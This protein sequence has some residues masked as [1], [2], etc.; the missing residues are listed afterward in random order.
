MFSEMIRTTLERE[1][2]GQPAAIAS[3]V[4]GITRLASGLTPRERSWCTYLFIGPPRDRTHAPG[5]HRGPTAAR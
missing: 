5:A 2:I 3:V 4:R 1:V